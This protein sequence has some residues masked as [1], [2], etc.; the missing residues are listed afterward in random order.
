VNLS[1]GGYSPLFAFFFFGAS[2]VVFNVPSPSGGGTSAFGFESRFR[3][4]EDFLVRVFPT[5]CGCVSELE[6]ARDV[7]EL[8]DEWGES[9]CA[10]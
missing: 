4:R 8:P 1:S 6:F 5:S 2:R 7:S 9:W 10:I 3:L